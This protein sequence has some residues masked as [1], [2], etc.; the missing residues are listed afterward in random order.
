MKITQTKVCINVLNVTNKHVHVHEVC[1]ALWMDSLIAIKL[2]IKRT[3]LFFL[4]KCPI[5]YHITHDFRHCPPY[6]LKKDL[7]FS[8]PL[9]DFNFLVPNEAV[10]AIARRWRQE[11]LQ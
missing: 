4:S 8:L 2:K 3:A 11:F 1:A 7:F 5:S 10:L 6:K 9:Q